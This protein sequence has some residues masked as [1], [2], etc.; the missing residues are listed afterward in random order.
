M[1]SGHLHFV[2]FSIFTLVS[3]HLGVNESSSQQISA[4]RVFLAIDDLIC[5]IRAHI[6]SY[7]LISYHP[8]QKL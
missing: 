7:Y 3:F 1:S 2:I 4:G 5:H 8:M 6:I